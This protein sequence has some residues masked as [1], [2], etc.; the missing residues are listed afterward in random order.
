M[1][2]LANACGYCTPG[3]ILSAI[4]CIDE[5]HANSRDDIRGVHE[6]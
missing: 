3:Q 4:A 6:R 5:G 2:A 1:G